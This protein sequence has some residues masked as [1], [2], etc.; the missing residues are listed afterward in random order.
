MTDLLDRA[1]LNL[2][3]TAEFSINR[4]DD[5]GEHVT[6][7]SADIKKPDD[8]AIDAEIARLV[9]VDEKEVG[10]KCIVDFAENLRKKLAKNPTHLKQQA[11]L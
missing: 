4:R 6:W 2:A 9:I 8:A 1:I 5:G 3:P 7:H 11:G 10:K